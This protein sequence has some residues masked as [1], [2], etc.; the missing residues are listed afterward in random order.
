MRNL[1]RLTWAANEV[2]GVPRD[3]DKRKRP[4][5]GF[6]GCR[7]AKARSAVDDKLLNGCW[8]HATD[9]DTTGTEGK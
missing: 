1:R 7:R 2:A 3:D 6:K 9:R 4:R 5:C 8:M